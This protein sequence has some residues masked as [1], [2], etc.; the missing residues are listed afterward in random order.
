MAALCL[1]GPS[2]ASLLQVAAAIQERKEAEVTCARLHRMRED[3]AGFMTELKK[4]RKKQFEVW[5]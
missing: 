5:V 3:K 2:A 4:N 1:P